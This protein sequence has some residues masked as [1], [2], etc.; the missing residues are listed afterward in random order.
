MRAFGSPPRQILALASLVVALAAGISCGAPS[1]SE[2]FSA[3]TGGEAETTAL[4][5]ILSDYF[6]AAEYAGRRTRLAAETDA[7]VVLLFGSKDP[8][9]A[10]DERRFDPYFR[11]RE[12]KQTEDVIYLTGVEEAGAVVLLQGDEGV[13]VLLPDAAN[14]AEAL[15]RLA[16]LG[17]SD[18]QPL[19]SLED[20]LE[21][22]VE[23]GLPLF[24]MQRERA[25]GGVGFGTGE[26]FSDLL[27]S[28]TAGTMPEDLVADRIRRRY[29]GT[30]VLNLLPALRRTWKAK[31]PAEIR[32]MRDVAQISVAGLI[33]GLRHVRP[34]VADREVASRIEGEM[35]RKGAQRL[36][37]AANIQSGP[38]LQKSFVQLFRDYDGGNRIMQTG[39]VVLIDH[40]AEFNY[41]ISDIA[42]TVPVDGTFSPEYRALYELYLVAYWAALDAIRPGNTW[43]EVGNA[44]SDAVTDQLDSIEEDWLLKSATTFVERYGQPTGGPGHFLGT[45]ISIHNDRTSPLV[46]GQIMAFE[47]VL[48]APEF[49]LRVTLEDVVAV[50]EDGHDVLSAGLPTTVDEVEELVGSAYRE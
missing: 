26:K 32:L 1:D 47:M 6:D 3:A 23:G 10:W 41:H 35:R 27:P 28:L 9:D 43:I 21:A 38:N 4:S 50:T 2:E 14:N 24:M 30:E 5:A 19:S 16:A 31:S 48:T 15:D 44:A 33:E 12:F 34:G 20:R 22:A 8:M 40:S 45:N 49:G 36:A 39:E 42:R 13:S 7:G 11:L 17:I 37:Y 29:R 18:V 25:E 46:P